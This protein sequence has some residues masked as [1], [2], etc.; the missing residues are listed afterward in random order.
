MVF[1]SEVQNGGFISLF[2]KCCFKFGRRYLPKIQHTAGD[3]SLAHEC[4]FVRESRAAT[5]SFDIEINHLF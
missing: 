2:Q 3:F 4:F 5:T 1:V